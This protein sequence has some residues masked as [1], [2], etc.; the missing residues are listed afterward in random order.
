MTWW[1]NGSRQVFT[2]KQLRKDRY[3]LVEKGA[4][5]HAQIEALGTTEMQLFRE[6]K[7]VVV[8]AKEKRGDKHR[9]EHCGD[10][11]GKFKSVVL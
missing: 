2:T 9:V 5:F 8:C 4:H 11:V 7:G 1:A 3:A 6:K 10:L